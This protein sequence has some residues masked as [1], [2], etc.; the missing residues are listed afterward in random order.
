MKSSIVSATKLA[1]MR[2]S[3]IVTARRESRQVYYSIRTHSLRNILF[4]ILKAA[5]SISA[6]EEFNAGGSLMR[7]GD[8]PRLLHAINPEEKRIVWMWSSVRNTIFVVLS[9]GVIALAGITGLQQ[10]RIHHQA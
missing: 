1:Q 5:E 4:D 6:Q 2:K 3:E 8:S 9:V 10:Y 7:Q